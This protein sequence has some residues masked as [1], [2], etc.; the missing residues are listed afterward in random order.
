MT[1]PKL[2]FSFPDFVRYP[3]HAVVY[4]LL[5]YF[6]YKEFTKTDECADLRTTVISQGNRI[7]KLEKDKDDLTWAIAVKSGVIDQLKSKR[8]SSLKNSGNENIN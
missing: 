5:A 1:M 3:L 4:V 7:A 2:P 6:V 8:D